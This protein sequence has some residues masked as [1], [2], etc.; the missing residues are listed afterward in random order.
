MQDLFLY[1]PVEVLVL[2]VALKIKQ[3]HAA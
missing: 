1:L 2:L 3:T